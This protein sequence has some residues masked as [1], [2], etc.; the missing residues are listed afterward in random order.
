[1]E[2]QRDD[3]LQETRRRWQERDA[4]PILP[5]FQETAKKVRKQRG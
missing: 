2:K 4:T 1:M 3:V 5:K